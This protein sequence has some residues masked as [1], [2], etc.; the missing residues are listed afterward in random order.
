MKSIFKHLV[1]HRLC[2]F[3]FCEKLFWEALPVVNDAF[4]VQ[5]QYGSKYLNDIFFTFHESNG[6]ICH[7]KY[8][9]S[10]GTKVMDLT[11]GEM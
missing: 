8:H 1:C 9:L 5:T 2:A 4:F 6:K 3:C 10:L 7:F 11:G